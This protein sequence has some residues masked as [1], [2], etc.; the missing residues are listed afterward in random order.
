MGLLKHQFLSNILQLEHH[1]TTSALRNIAKGNAKVMHIWVTSVPISYSFF[2]PDFKH[3]KMRTLIAITLVGSVAL[4]AAV[5]EDCKPHCIK[6][7][8]EVAGR[9]AGSTDCLM[10]FGMGPEG[11]GWYWPSVT[12]ALIKQISGHIVEP[13]AGLRGRPC[14]ESCQLTCN[15]ICKPM[16]DGGDKKVAANRYGYYGHG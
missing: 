11:E 16:E 14:Q 8:L 5:K 2:C 13:N 6:D 1:H 4:A 3:K 7:C 9:N 10:M 12:V 15:N